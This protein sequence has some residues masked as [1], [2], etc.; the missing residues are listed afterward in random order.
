MISIQ[1]K[2]GTLII[3]EDFP[4]SKVVSATLE[5]KVNCITH[6]QRKLRLLFSN[7][8]IASFQ[9]IFKLYRFFNRER[10][11]ECMLCNNWYWV[12]EE[13]P[14][15]LQEVL[16]KFFVF[17]AGKIRL[18]LSVN[19]MLWNAIQTRMLNHLWLFLLIDHVDWIHVDVKAIVY[20]IC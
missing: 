5:T 6:D 10:H 2:D 14:V 12:G 3:I 7:Q 8:V 13:A 4:A 19:E 20:C 11:R 1:C 16:I 17:I 18:K 9:Y 15:E